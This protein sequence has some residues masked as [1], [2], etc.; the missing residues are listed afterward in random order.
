MAVNYTPDYQSIDGNIKTLKPFRFWC[1]KVLPLVYDDSLS[2]YELLNKVVQY[3]NDTMENV[4]GL[5]D[6]VNTLDENVRAIYQ[7][8][9]Q[10][11][12]YVNNYFDNLDVQEEIN[13][14]LDDM[15][16]D[17]TLSTMIRTIATPMIPELVEDWLEENIEPTTPAVDRSLSVSG[18]AADAKVTGDNFRNVR[19]TFNELG[20][21]FYNLFNPDNL[22]I[23]YYLA[24]TGGL[25]ENANFATTDFIDISNYETLMFSYTNFGAWYTTNDESGFISPLNSTDMNS[26]SADKTATVPEGAKFL[27]VTVEVSNINLSQIGQEVSRLNYISHNR[28]RLIYADIDSD[29]IKGIK[30]LEDTLGYSYYNLFNKNDIYN[31]YYLAGN[32]GLIANANYA[33]S[34]FLNVEGYENIMFS[35]TNFGA[36]YSSD[37]ESSFISPLNTS[38]MNSLAIDKMATVPEGAKYLRVTVQVSNLDVVQVGER[39]DRNKYISHDKIYLRDVL[40]DMSGDNIIVATD[41]S[42]NYTSL[43]EALYENIENDKTVIV[44]PGTYNIA[45][46]YVALFGQDAVDNLADNTT[47][48]ND[49]QYGIRIKNRKV[50]FECGSHVICDWTGHTVDGTHRFSAFR[51]EQGAEIEGLFLTATAV[52]YAIHDDYGPS[53]PFTIK[54]DNCHIEG[55][56]IYNANCIGG[57]CH[58][59][60]KHILTN[61][62]FDNHSNSNDIVLSAEVRYHNTNTAGAEPEVYVSNCYFAH[63]MNV[64]YYGAQTTKMRAYINNCFAPNGINKVRESSSMSTDNIDL[65]AWNNQTH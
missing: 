6:N 18:A 58:K 56:N 61:C 62:Y 40:F 23:G 48:I 15:A 53:T 49:F 64:A 36:W 43:T 17:G 42:G 65:Y 11:Q 25:I 39:V 1:Q 10:L 7:A 13:N 50:I 24:G 32:G 9:N 5:N 38:E 21:I 16:S 44:K 41:G 37:D 2:Y 33:T 29:Q 30:Y 19:D 14:K 31:G 4:D 46:E 57:G 8:Y 52:Y 22:H 12:D 60:S 54:Y 45:S 55:Y 51:V 28:Y 63:N 27:R 26:L 3:L 20:V 34:K 59:Y 47:G 35:Y